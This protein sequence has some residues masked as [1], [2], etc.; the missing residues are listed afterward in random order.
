MSAARGDPARPPA[1]L[2]ARSLAKLLR[3]LPGVMYRVCHK[4][5][6]LVDWSDNAE[7]RFSSPAMPFK[8]LYLA[9]TKITGFWERFGEELRDQEPE[10]RKIQEADLKARVWKQFVLT[11]HAPARLLDLR[12][13]DTLRSISADASTFLSFYDVTHQWAK[14]LMEHPDEI[15]GLIY[16]SRQDPQQ[17]CVAIFGRPKFVAKSRFLS[18]KRMPPPPLKDKGFLAHLIRANVKVE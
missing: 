10:Y 5:A 7:S 12:D 16:N 11:E 8:V 2:G 14:A 3:P 1:T 18:V 4:K 15:D 17:H 6:P 13:A 9:P